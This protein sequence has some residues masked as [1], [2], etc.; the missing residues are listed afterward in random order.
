M[1]LECPPG[2]SR[3]HRRTPGAEARDLRLR[4]EFPD[5]AQ[6]LSSKRRKGV[7][8]RHRGLGRKEWNQQTADDCQR[9]EAENASTH[10]VFTLAFSALSIEA[11]YGVKKSKDK[12][13]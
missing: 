11:G 3:S 10:C 4:T 2:A 13:V 12:Q 5:I 8:L 6:A 1:A 9:C 7:G